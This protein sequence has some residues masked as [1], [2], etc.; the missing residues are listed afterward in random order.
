MID[1]LTNRLIVLFMCN[2]MQL[3]VTESHDRVKCF[4]VYHVVVVRV[5]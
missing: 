3:K 5:T 2:I 4:I 1:D